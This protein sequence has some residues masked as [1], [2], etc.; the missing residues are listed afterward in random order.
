MRQQYLNGLK[1]RVSKTAM[2]LSCEQVAKSLDF[3]TIK[4]GNQIY[5][6]CPVCGA[7]A[8]DKKCSINASTNLWHCF[9][10]E[11]GGGSPKFYA[12]AAHISWIDACVV[13]SYKAGEITDE[14]YERLMNE[15]VNR[16]KLNS[17][18][19]TYQKFD[20]A[21]STE[22]CVK[23]PAEITDLVYRHMLNLPQFK[24]SD[25]GYAHLV[26]R[27]LTKSEIKSG[28]FF[29]YTKEFNISDLLISIQKEKPDF[30]PTHFN[31]VPGFYFL[32]SGDKKHGWWLFKPPYPNCLGI[33]LKDCNGRIVALQMR[34]MEARKGDNK[35]FYVS[36]L[37]QKD[38]RGKTGYGCS[39]G[40]P[41]HVE[42]PEGDI[43]SPVIFIGEGVFKMREIAK[44]G[45]VALSIQGVNS[46]HYVAEEINELMHCDT[47]IRKTKNLT[48]RRM[49]FVICF[50]ADMNEKV[51]VLKASCSFIEYLNG[52]FP[53]REVYIML[54]D[55][56]LGKG[57]DDMKQE[58][59]RTGTDYRKKRCFMPGFR[60]IEISKTAVLNSDRLYLSAH[61]GGKKGIEI[62]QTPEWKKY[63]SEEMYDKAVKPI[64]P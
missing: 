42:Y 13:L 10:C 1:D 44:D 36:S 6:N 61:P 17:D 39:P 15:A 45:S 29:S 26:K 38:R 40:T 46:Y 63:L 16:E 14:E 48:D 59:I 56:T 52:K 58:C 12:E 7:N 53:G 35:Y 25:G 31:G 21:K 57:Y 55:K 4:R 51:E 24:L 3:P 47:V 27:G 28:G 32:F 41:V 60:F 11:A 33:P 37:N 50:D 49:R 22:A 62:R 8:S 18:T 54:W 20:T 30:T 9:G 5:T 34:N 43:T 23:A 64:L 19:V 2:G